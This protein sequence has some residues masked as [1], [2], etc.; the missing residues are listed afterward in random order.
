M[1]TKAPTVRRQYDEVIAPHYDRDPQSVLGDSLGRAMAQLRSHVLHEASSAPLEVLDVGL[2]TG[3]FL[4]MLRPAA[5]G[6]LRPCGLD[7]SARM[8]A[9]ARQRVPGLEVAVDDAANL[10]PISPASRS[11]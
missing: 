1:I 4:E 10:T 2:G 8:V 7:L 3:R 11:T 9:A 5:R 6:G